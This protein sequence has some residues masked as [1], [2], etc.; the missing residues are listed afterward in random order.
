MVTQIVMRFYK[1]SKEEMVNV[2]KRIHDQKMAALV[3]DN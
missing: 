3:K 1:L 2:Q